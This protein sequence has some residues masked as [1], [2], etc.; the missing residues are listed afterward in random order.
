M[1]Q[2]ALPIA[3]IERAVVAALNEARH[4]QGISLRALEDKTT[5]SR[6][7][8]SR[9]LRSEVSCSL[10]EFYELC[11][12]MGLV[13]SL[14]VHEAE[15]AVSKS[16]PAPAPSPVAPLR[17]ASEPS[18]P[19]PDFARL[20]AKR[21]PGRAREIEERTGWREDLGEEPQDRPDREG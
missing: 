1:G 9:I 14:V 8:A 12:A 15:L 4:T 19:L 13:P 18:E 10:S 21:I 2:N 11:R 5:V 3:A 20:A 6:A 17:T 7:R 16:A